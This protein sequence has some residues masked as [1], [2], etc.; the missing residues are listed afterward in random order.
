MKI[1]IVLFIVGFALGMSF[2][3]PISKKPA[4]VVYDENVLYKAIIEKGDIGAYK[5]SIGHSWI[6]DPLYPILMVNRYKY[7]D[8][9]REF[10]LLI[11]NLDMNYSKGPDTTSMCIARWMAT[12]AKS[13][14]DIKWLDEIES[15][16]KMKHKKRMR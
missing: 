12:N 13:E 5:K 7:N 14:D 2:S 11:S 10:L 15:K 4:K 8:A 6:I 16:W 9:V 3:L 1:R